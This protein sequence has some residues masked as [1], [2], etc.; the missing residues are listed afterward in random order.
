M[1]VG[2]GC[3]RESWRWS[4][5]CRQVDHDLFFPVGKSGEAAV[6]IKRAK[7]VCASCPVREA[8]LAFALA[9]NQEFG[10][11]GGYDERE[12]PGL[13]RKWR[14]ARALTATEQQPVIVSL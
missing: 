7:A 12:R 6:E 14:A 9:T 8:C 11:W 10:I 5:A 2:R 13:R 4:A 1:G 3:D